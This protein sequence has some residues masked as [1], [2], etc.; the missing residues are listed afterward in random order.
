MFAPKKPAFA[1][2]KPDD[3]L[4]SLPQPPYRE[5]SK[6]IV[7]TPIHPLLLSVIRIRGVAVGRLVCWA[8]Q[9]RDPV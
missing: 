5:P 1:E 6:L 9:Q 8:R 4:P 3:S 2:E 7:P